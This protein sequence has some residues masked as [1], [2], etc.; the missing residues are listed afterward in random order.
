[1]VKP[2][3]KAF[4]LIEL[5]VVIS[6][7]ALLVSILMPALNKAKQQATMAVCLNNEKQL[8]VAWTMYANENDDIMVRPQALNGD[9]GDWVSWPQNIDGTDVPSSSFDQYA[10]VCGS[11]EEKNGIEN[12]ALFKYYQDPELLH[13]PGDK[14]ALKEPAA[15]VAKSSGMGA[16]RTYSIVGVLNA[17]GYGTNNNLSSVSGAKVI[18]NASRIKIPQEKYIFIEDGDTRGYNLGGWEIDPSQSPYMQ[19]IDNIGIYHNDKG[20]FGF[21]D[22]HADVHQWEDKDTITHFRDM[23]QTG[24]GF[25][26][27]DTS[28]NLDVEWLC[29]HYPSK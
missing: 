4:T 24:S 18:R 20:T 13:C 15:S 7:I 5:L 9:W 25:Y 29:R 22:G 3:A 2:N 1:M 16:W 10:P 11:E 17:R 23:L 19:F 6:I 28:A 26:W 27:S 21:A 12:G 14:R 8:V